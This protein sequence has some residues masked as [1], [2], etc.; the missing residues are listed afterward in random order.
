MREHV[1]AALFILRLRD[2]HA[3]KGAVCKSEKC[4]NIFLFTP[5]RRS[6]GSAQRARGMAEH[7][8]LLIS[9]GTFALRG[10]PN[11]GWEPHLLARP[12]RAARSNALAA[13]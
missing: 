9:S 11:K 8:A 2:F 5:A 13:H 10:H 3:M 12:V 4:R 7:R 1:L 6:L